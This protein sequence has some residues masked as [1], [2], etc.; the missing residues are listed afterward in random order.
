MSEYSS[1]IFRYIHECHVLCT[2]AQ[3]QTQG[4]DAD[5]EFYRTEAKTN[6]EYAA[7]MTNKAMTHDGLGEARALATSACASSSTRFLPCD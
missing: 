5:V 2:Y 3:A 1:V 4:L 7:L 6:E